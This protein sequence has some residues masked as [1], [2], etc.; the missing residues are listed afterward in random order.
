M[1]YIERIKLKRFKSFK[2]ADIPLSKGFVCLAGPNGSGK[3]NICDGIRFALGENSFK[4]LRAK[5]VADLITRGSE[6]A[7]IYLQFD[8]D[9][10]HELKRAIRNDGK[11]LYKLDG[12]RMTRTD[13]LDELSR[14]GISAGN[15]NVIAQGEVERIVNIN[16]KE[17]REIIDGVAGISEFEDKKKE[18]LAELAKVEQKINDATIVLKEREGF[19]TELEKDK[20]DAL[21]YN[22]INAGLRKYRGSLLFIELKK[23]EKEFTRSTN[24]YLELKNQEE[25]VN[26]RVAEIDSKIKE[27]ESQKNGITQQINE[28]AE[29]EKNSL[30]REVEQL[31][32]SINLAIG[33]REQK[34]REVDR[35]KQRVSSL[36]NEKI[37]L[38]AK[39][40]QLAQDSAGMKEKIA[41]VEGQILAFLNER[42]KASK[43]TALGS[44]FY[45]AK[46]KSTN[47]LKQLE[48]RKERIRKLELDVEKLT[49]RRSFAE[50][51]LKRLESQAP[52]EKTERASEISQDAEELRKDSKEIDSQL[53]S[54]FEKEKELNQK[55]PTTEKMLLEVKEKY[56]GIASKMQ[57]L[58]EL[59]E[60]Q[61]VRAL[62]DLK[63]NGMLP[64]IYGTVGEL[65]KFD[66]EYSTAIEV[67]AGNRM[68]YLV[69]EDVNTAA[70]AIE[71]L[72]KTRAGR[73]TFIP[74]D[75]RAHFITDEQRTLSKSEGSR[76]FLL[77][78]VSFDSKYSNVFQFVFGDTLLIDSI[79]SAKKVGIGK[80]RMVTLEGDL[81]ESSGTITGGIVKRVSSHAKERAEAERLNSELEA[82]KA[83]RDGIVNSLY[84]LREDM[85]KKRREKSEL[86]VKLKGFELELAH[87]ADTKSKE[88]R[89]RETY[90][91]NIASLKHEINLSSKELSERQADSEKLNAEIAELQK[92]NENSL[93]QI[94]A[95]KEEQFN[96]KMQEFEK[97][98][99]DFNSTKTSYE[100]ELAKC[101][102]ELDMMKKRA[103]SIDEECEPLRRDLNVLK[104]DLK[105]LES[106]L[107][108]NNKLYEEKSAKIKNVSSDLEKL[109]ENRNGIERQ[110]E[111]LALEKGKSGFNYE[112]FFKD[113]TR[114]EIMKANLE[115]RLTDLKTESASYQDIEQVEGAKEDIEAKIVEGEQQLAALGDVNLK[116]PKEYEERVKEM[117]DVKE[118]TEKLAAE[119]KAVQSMI[120]EIETKK[121][122]I[123]ME[124][125]EVVRKNFVK[126]Y[127]YA[128]TTGEGDL[129]LQNPEAPLES[130]LQIQLKTEKGELQFIESKSGGEKSL[131]TLMFIFS[132]QMYKPAPFYLLD[133]ADASLDK[134]NSLKL[135]Q[136]LKELSKNTQFIVVTHNDAVLT[137]ADTAIGVTRT[138]EGSKIVGVQFNT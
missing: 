96:R 11:T 44:K 37:S 1:V 109:Y 30:F 122:A 72:K 25:E 5:K 98:L 4:S 132:I 105:E 48:E 126:L 81:L 133:E 22:E 101:T 106:S 56:V 131:L 94:D 60:N 12:K 78:V 129:V 24:K 32:T 58:K 54:L 65:C 46:M 38:N 104:S 95:E 7:E 102:A 23:V 15:H 43:E 107:A 110:I 53:S 17:R 18:A 68:N 124:T 89:G 69:V 127:G 76:G 55:L 118:K 120:D 125:F 92:A 62:L 75:I 99:N 8:G 66:D 74:L 42:D 119:R 80:A 10:K 84:S 9:K 6:K 13:V 117:K 134:E 128:F 41:D 73:C 39:M 136:L 14:M 100:G 29:R 21:K 47:L 87:I 79:E 67:A 16:P 93:K 57:F 28:K 40:I 27:L 83:E 50:M 70:K 3:S 71:Y 112:K 2:Y 52:S 121:S 36:E 59:P 138:K 113:L 111:A 115:T 116:A 82:L 103:Q 20:N 49:S 88:R 63:K 114:Y 61:G 45:E 19:L 64:G 137:S 130:G 108:S 31:K 85:S 90:D 91:A 34:E 97:Q 51:E 26:K 135:S 123:F 86:E 77:E 35:I 33:S